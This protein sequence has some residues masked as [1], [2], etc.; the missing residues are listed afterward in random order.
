VTPSGQAA[1]AAAVALALLVLGG[2]VARRKLGVCRFFVVYL[3]VATAAD[4]L[5]LLWP[6]Y[7]FTQ[8]FWVAKEAAIHLLRFA[9][10]LELTYRTFQAFPS[11]RSSARMLALVVLGGTF[12]IL[13]AGAGNLGE[14]G[15]TPP[16]GP[17]ISRV[18]PMVLNGSVWLLTAMAGLILWY[19]LPVHPWHKAIIMGLVVYLLV[20]STSLSWI[21]SRGWAEREFANHFMRAGYLSLLAYWAVAAWRRAEAPIHPPAGIQDAPEP[22][23]GRAS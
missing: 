6:R 23:L 22:S 18:Q 14:P 2:L 21:E 4:I 9:V 7:F 1:L 17:V 19:R 13:L 11:A 15:T 12:V 20:F 8:P 16:L 5:I 3:S 10:I